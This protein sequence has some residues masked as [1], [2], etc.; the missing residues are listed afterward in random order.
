LTL[1]AARQPAPPDGAT[2]PAWVCCRW[3]CSLI[4][5]RQAQAADPG[6]L[7]ASQL[8]ISLVTTSLVG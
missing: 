2:I 3:Y 7:N 1:P 8:N 4:G 5:I 6:Q